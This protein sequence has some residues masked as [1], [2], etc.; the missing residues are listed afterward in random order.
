MERE[1]LNKLILQI[2]L[3]TGLGIMHTTMLLKNNNYDVEKCLSKITIKCS[4]CGKSLRVIK[5]NMA[6]DE[7]PYICGECGFI[8][9]I[10]E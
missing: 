10:P 9:P 7:N 1:E 8:N 3:K 2:R 4:N 6:M 5:D